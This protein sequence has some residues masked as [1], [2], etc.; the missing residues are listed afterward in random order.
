MHQMIFFY[1]LYFTEAQKR[2]M[3]CRALEA[4]LLLQVQLQVAV[5]LFFTVLHIQHHWSEIY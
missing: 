2:E 4:D 3:V 5:S 1:I